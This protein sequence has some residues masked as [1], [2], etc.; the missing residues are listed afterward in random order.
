MLK[1]QICRLSLT[2]WGWWPKFKNVKKLRLDRILCNMF[3]CLLT[4][5]QDRCCNDEHHAVTVP[6]Y[7][8]LLGII[9]NP[10]HAWGKSPTH[11]Y[12][13]ANKKAEHHWWF[14]SDLG[15]RVPASIISCIV[16]TSHFYRKIHILYR[17]P[18]VIVWNAF[19][20]SYTES[21]CF[22]VKLVFG[23]Q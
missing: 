16:S 10:C 18:C 4:L 14:T 17:P 21:L 20:T 13:Y 9:A 2:S 23:Y 15:N 8:P 1:I 7:Q 12:N 19:Q 22:C 6:K 11:N 3:V 5:L